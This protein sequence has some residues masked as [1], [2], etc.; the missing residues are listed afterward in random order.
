MGITKNIG[1]DRCDIYIYIYIYKIMEPQ[2]TWEVSCINKYMLKYY[3][4]EVTVKERK[5]FI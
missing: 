3:D 4:N 5:Y 1:F 2:N